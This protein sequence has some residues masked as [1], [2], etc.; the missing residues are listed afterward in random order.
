[1]GLGVFTNPCGGKRWMTLPSGEIEVEG[2][3]VPAYVPG[4]AGFETLVRTWQNWKPL[5]RASANKYDAPLSWLVA[6]ANVE[7]GLWSDNPA[8]QATIV[9]YANAIGVMQ[10]IPSTASML[11]FSASDMYD[12]AK[13]IDA[14]AKLIAQLRAKYY[15]LPPISAVYNSGRL[16]SPGRNEWNLLADGNY[17]RKAILGNNAAIEHLDLGM[18]TAKMIGLG[19]IGAGVLAAG[20][21]ALGIVEPP[22]LLSKWG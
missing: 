19:L 21:I 14:G 4:D 18:S 10:V 8:K 15:E 12:P 9:S 16:C 13:N 22:R 7:T 2:E 6:V 11:G 17:P 5:F 3:G 20:A 1:M